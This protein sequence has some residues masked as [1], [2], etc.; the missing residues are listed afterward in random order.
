M[1]TR[2]YGA[3]NI[4]YILLVFCSTFR[5]QLCNF[6]N[7]SLSTLVFACFRRHRFYVICDIQRKFLGNKIR[8]LKKKI[9]V[10]DVVKNNSLPISFPN[11]CNDSEM[12]STFPHWVLKIT[13]NRITSFQKTKRLTHICYISGI[14]RGGFSGK[15]IQFLDFSL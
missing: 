13:L 12:E 14:F 4:L 1:L 15:N 10:F 8:R 5:G 3:K 6:P 2:I 7:H 11:F 9:P